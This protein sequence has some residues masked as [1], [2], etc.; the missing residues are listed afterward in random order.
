MSRVE[1]WNSIRP[2]P[3]YIP[4]LGRGA[5]GFTTRSD[6][7][8]SKFTPTVQTNSTNA[9]RLASYTSRAAIPLDLGY[10]PFKLIDALK[11]SAAACHVTFHTLRY[12]ALCERTQKRSQPTLPM[13]CCSKLSRS[14]KRT[15]P[16]LRPTNPSTTSWAMTLV[17]LLMATTIKTTRKQTRL[18]PRSKTSWTSG[19]RCVC[20]HFLSTL[21]ITHSCPGRM[22]HI[23][24]KRV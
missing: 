13:L 9:V 8:P 18:T 16:P 3:H 19:G 1:Y 10:Q 14:K 23:E 6:I 22:Q 4:G 2:D 11:T 12:A 21:S 5:Q 15:L 20:C 17:R 7:G 24:Q